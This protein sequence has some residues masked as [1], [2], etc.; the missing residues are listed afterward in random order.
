MTLVL[1]AFA[2]EIAAFIEAVQEKKKSKISLGANKDIYY[3]LGQTKAGNP[4]AA[5]VT[6]IG[7]INSYIS[8]LE[9]IKECR[10]DRV[11]FIGIAG[12]V[13][14]ELKI[15]DVVLSETIT[16]YDIDYYFDKVIPGGTSGSID[17]LIYTDKNLTDKIDT[18]VRVLLKRENFQRTFAVGCTGSAD[19]FMTP[20]VNAKYGEV[21][22]RRDVIAVDMEGFSAATAALVRNIPFAQVRVISDEADGTKPDASKFREFLRNTSVYL[23]SVIGEILS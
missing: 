21:L 20:E 4:V 16:Q 3:T 2:G 11:V 13:S 19:I 1:S 8:T 5:A 6:G 14:P 9:I 7:K 12:S 17:G 15:G 10:P 22:T 18:A 23:A